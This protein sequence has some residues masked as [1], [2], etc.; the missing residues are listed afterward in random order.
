MTTVTDRLWK[1]I[2]EITRIKHPS[3]VEVLRGRGF[4]YEAGPNG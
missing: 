2:T 3:V 4:G 1:A